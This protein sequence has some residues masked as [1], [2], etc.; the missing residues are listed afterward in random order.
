MMRTL[1][2][3]TIAGAMLTVSFGWAQQP[4]KL[5]HSIRRITGVVQ[6]ARGETVPNIDVEVFGGQNLIA[7]ARTDSHGKFQTDQLESGEYEVWFTY[8]P[9]PVFHDAEYKVTVDPKGSKDPWIV[10]LQPLS[11]AEN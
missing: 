8:K 7:A 3:A 6:N 4:V 9:H 5:D 2:R 11:A 1:F 10:K